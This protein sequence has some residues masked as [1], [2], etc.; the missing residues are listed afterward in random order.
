MTTRVMFVAGDPSGDQHAAA[1]IR[2]LRQSLPGVRTFGIG[3]PC[4]QAEGFETL[5]PFAPFNRMGFAEV[6]RHLPF[7]LSAKSYLVKT[8]REQRPQ[9]LV[10]VDY[11]GFNIPL[12]K[13]AH[14]LGIPVVWY[15]VPQ[16]WAW[17][18]KRA[19]VLGRYASFIAVVFPFEIDY[20]S[21]YSAPVAF[22][23]HPLV[24]MLQAGAWPG[25]GRSAATLDRSRPLRLAVVPG[26]RPQEIAHMLPPMMEAAHLLK[27]RYPDLA[28]SLS[29]CAALPM[30]LFG[31]ELN[32]FQALHPDA[33]AVS[34]QPLFDLLAGAD[35]ALVTSGTATLQ[36]A[37]SGV[38][39]V[40]AY[41]T[42]VLTYSLMKPMVRLPYIGLPNIIAG[43][44]IVPECIQHR[45]TG[46]ILAEELRRYVES[47]SHYE[48]TAGRLASLRQKLGRKRPSH[49][50]VS[51][52]CSII[53]RRT[54]AGV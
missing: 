43:E 36:T 27:Q 48:A 9:A 53:A 11:P 23:G 16:V 32:R 25:G 6:L 1:V 28:V 19:A 12:M 29:K 2:R 13:K 45:V 46:Q 31:P 50:V 15:I 44:K 41:K 8:L 17:K 34:E 38:P 54:G 37:L 47:P 22:V 30:K 10:C 4:M 18:Q 20:F 26:S 21:P 42:S 51:A 7:F 3:G 52:L 5:L 14:G 39:M 24:E 35:L 40:I 49:E 33:C